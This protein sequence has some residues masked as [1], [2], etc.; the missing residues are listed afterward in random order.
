MI[1]NLESQITEIYQCALRF[2]YY[3]QGIFPASDMDFACYQFKDL[4]TEIKNLCINDSDKFPSY[5]YPFSLKVRLSLDCWGDRKD[6][7]ELE[8][9]FFK[10]SSRKLAC[11]IWLC[12]EPM[13]KYINFGNLYITHIFKIKKK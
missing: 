4:E 8:N 11:D 13:N 9:I 2:L 7:S 3:E 5:I 1:L 10:S 12:N 6:F